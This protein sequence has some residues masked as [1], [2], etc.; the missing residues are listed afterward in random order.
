MLD[1]LRA[2]DPG[3]ADVRMRQGNNEDAAS[4]RHAW[5]GAERLLLVS[6][7]AAASGDDPLSQHT[8]AIA[9]A[10]ELGVRRVFYARKI[11]RWDRHG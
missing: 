10:R 9:V 6:S 7:S 8:V 4:L 3:A 5:E 11:A 1:G 2:A